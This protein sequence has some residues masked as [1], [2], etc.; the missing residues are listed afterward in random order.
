MPSRV[1]HSIDQSLK[2]I[3]TCSLFA[4]ETRRSFLKLATVGGVMCAATPLFAFSKLI[5]DR[6]YSYHSIS[7]DAMIVQLKLLR[8]AKSN[9]A[10]EYC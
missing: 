8:I 3:L 9:I 10:D 4:G 6:S 7:L 5:C 2:L 1:V